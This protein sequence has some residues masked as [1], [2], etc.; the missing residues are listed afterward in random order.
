M[1]WRLE[2]VNSF[3][4]GYRIYL[5]EAFAKWCNISKTE[6]LP[7]EKVFPANDLRS[8]DDVEFSYASIADTYN[9]IRRILFSTDLFIQM[10]V[11]SN[12]SMTRVMSDYL[13]PK[14]AT[15]SYGVNS[16]YYAASDG[17]FSEQ[18]P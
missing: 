4:A 12:Y 14:T 8:L 11:S 15:L 13:M 17:T 3:R 18:L 9:R 2:F 6:Y 10:E 5:S 1:R 16:G 7:T